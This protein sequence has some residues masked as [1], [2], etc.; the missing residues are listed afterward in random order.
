VSSAN[1]HAG[2]G[3][4]ASVAV[5]RPVVL[6]RYR[7]EVTG[8]TA[9]TV[10]VVPL[11]TDER[12]GVV[13]AL[14]GAVLMV[15]DIE[16]VTLGQGMPCT[17]CVLTQALGTVPPGESDAD[18]AGLAAGGITYQGWGWPVT[19][20]RDQVRLSLHRDVSARAIPVPLGTEILTR[21][22]CAPPVLAHPYA[23]DHRIVLTGERS[24]VPLPW[25]HQVHQISGVLLLPPTL[26]PRGP[27]TWI[28]PPQEDS[29]QLCREIDF[30][31]AL[32][33]ALRD[34]SAV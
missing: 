1:G 34:S 16:I 3:A 12:A 28:H 21:R 8:E 10:H 20:Y 19:L 30:F 31:G 27:I 26:T 9:R 18:A 2:P 32:R 15:H 29:L 4:G 5:A 7:L 6:V 23:P 22:R 11:H 17:L 33:T 24:G 25:P 14:C 13:G